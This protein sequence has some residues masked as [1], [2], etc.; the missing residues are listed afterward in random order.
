VANCIW[1]SCI[2]YGALVA[3]DDVV[4]FEIDAE[5]IATG[6]FFLPLSLD[7]LGSLPR[8][9]DTVNHWRTSGSAQQWFPL[10][11]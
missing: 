8:L 11:G 3:T 6:G 5:S 9:R 4:A 10:Y 2:Q 7:H 1:L